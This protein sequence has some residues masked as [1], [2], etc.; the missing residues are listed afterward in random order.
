MQ[1][2]LI[3]GDGIEGVLEMG[4]HI[5][6]IWVLF[7]SITCGIFVME[8]ESSTIQI[9]FCEYISNTLIFVS[10]MYV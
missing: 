5:L 9:L 10:K 6:P 1:Q 2:E 8:M 7:L 4:E 3:N